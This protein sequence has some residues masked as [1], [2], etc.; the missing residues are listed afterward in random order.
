MLGKVFLGSTFQ[1]VFD[2]HAGGDKKDQSLLWVQCSSYLSNVYSQMLAAILDG[3][4]VSL[5]WVG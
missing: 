1:M 5:G 2:C 4:D 3:S